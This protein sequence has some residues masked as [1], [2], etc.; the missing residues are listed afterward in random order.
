MTG[1]VWG[2]GPPCC[3][4]APP[5]GPLPGPNVLD[6]GGGWNCRSGWIPPAFPPIMSAE[7]QP[8][9]CSSLSIFFRR[10]SSAM[11]VI[12]IHSMPIGSRWSP[13]L[14]YT[15]TSISFALSMLKS[16]TSSV[17][18]SFLVGL[19]RPLI[20]SSTLILTKVSGPRLN[21]PVAA[22]STSATA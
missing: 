10:I 19:V 21:R 13:V 12:R 5:G 6:P 15:V 9:F 2:C 16:C 14:S 1:P 18:R 22:W 11:S 20:E 4:I 17:H 7:T 3:L 8:E